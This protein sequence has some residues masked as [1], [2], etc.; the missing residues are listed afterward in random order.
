MG[1]CCNVHSIQ[2]SSYEENLIYF[3]SHLK[4]NTMNIK[5][6]MKVVDSS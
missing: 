2:N 4:I 1:V 5:E 6:I 3:F